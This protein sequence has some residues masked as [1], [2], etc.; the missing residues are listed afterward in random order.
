M[1]KKSISGVI[2][3]NIQFAVLAL[4]AFALIF[5]F[6]YLPMGGLV[7]AFKNF[8]VKAGIFGSPWVS[9]KNFQFFFTSADAFRVMRN[10]VLLNL[11]FIAGKLVCSVAFAMLLFRLRSKGA[12]KF[13]QTTTII[14][15]FLSWVVVGFMAFT[16]LDPTRGLINHILASFGAAPVQWYSAPAYWPLILLITSLWQGVGY[17]SILYFANLMGI[18]NDYLEAASLDGASGRQTFAYVILPYLVP[19]ITILTIL[20]IGRIFRADFGLFFNVTRNVG[21]LYPTTDVI[22]TY[23]FRALMKVG[24]VGM[25]A[26]VGFFQSIVGFVMIL[27]ANLIVHRIE[28]ENALF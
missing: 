17:G 26:A 4:P 16:L 20:D 18:E 9:F 27:G 5:V 7:M 11:L 3:D 14:P 21:A 1:R 2:L 10:T 28:P 23:I 13:Y 15:Y 19:L 12:V 25:S 22:D 8:Q 24:D 6:S